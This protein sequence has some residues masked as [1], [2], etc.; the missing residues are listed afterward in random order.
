MAI[1]SGSY[2]GHIRI[3][4]GYQDLVGKEWI[5][6]YIYTYIYIYVH[7]CIYIYNED[8]K[9][10]NNEMGRSPHGS[11]VPNLGLEDSN[12]NGEISNWFRRPW[13]DAAKLLP[14]TICYRQNCAILTTT[15]SCHCIIAF[16]S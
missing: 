2:Q 3:I 13:R 12:C 11:W 10:C 14:N 7:M 9:R 8:K 6:I 1:I 16:N 4:S 15:N 5:Y